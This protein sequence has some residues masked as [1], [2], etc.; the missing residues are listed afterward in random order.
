MLSSKLKRL[1]HLLKWESKKNYN[2]FRFGNIIQKERG[3]GLNF[4]EVRKYIFGDDTRYIDWN[5]TS[6]LGDIHI[7]EYDEEKDATILI[8]LDRSKSVIQ[9]SESLSIQIALFFSIFHTK[10]GNKVILIPF[11]TTCETKFKV[12]KRETEVYKYF[13]E[14]EG[15]NFGKTTNFSQTLEHAY[16]S[17]PKHVTTYWIS[18]F[19]QFSGFGKI[20]NLCKTWDQNAILIYDSLDSIELP[21][22][23]N[24]FQKKSQESKEVLSNTSSL[25]SDRQEVIKYF[26]KQVVQVKDESTFAKEILPLF[27][28]IK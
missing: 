9:S 11:A 6:R 14:L 25:K 24:I 18:D 26:G 12:I 4:R 10:I 19:A 8:F 20:G 22:F 27:S 13:M 1:I 28:R 17:S 23:F 15:Q 3:R 21:K 16:K 7:R 5:V 2:G